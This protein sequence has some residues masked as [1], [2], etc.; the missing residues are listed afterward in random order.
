MAQ[1]RFMALSTATC[2]FSFTKAWAR[3]CALY[4]VLYFV[5]LHVQKGICIQPHTVRGRGILRLV[6]MKQG[7]AAF[8]MQ[9]VFAPVSPQFHPGLSTGRASSST[10]ALWVNYL[11]FSETV[12]FQGKG[13]KWMLLR[14]WAEGHVFLPFPSCVWKNTAPNQAL[15]P[16]IL[17]Y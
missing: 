3:Y 4:T 1:H 7:N 2:K 12:Q 14:K 6:E 10:S 9:L 15:N 13:Q 17:N 11:L 8:S 5:Y 16:C